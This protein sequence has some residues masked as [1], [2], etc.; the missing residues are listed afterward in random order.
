MF[1][2]VGSIASV[3]RSASLLPHDTR[4]RRSSTSRGGLECAKSY[5][6]IRRCTVEK[7][8]VV[9][10]ICPTASRRASS[11]DERLRERGRWS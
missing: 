7:D 10:V 3:R 8:E 6:L 2:R 1:T 9:G 11:D 4:R 5:V